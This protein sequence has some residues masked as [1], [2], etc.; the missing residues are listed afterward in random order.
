MINTGHRVR[1]ARSSIWC[2]SG[3]HIHPQRYTLHSPLASQ[4]NSHISSLRNQHS[5]R[6]TQVKYHTKHGSP[7]CCMAKQRFSVLIFSRHTHTKQHSLY[8]FQTFRFSSLRL[9]LN[10]LTWKIWWAPNNFS[11]WQMG[12][13]SAFKGLNNFPNW[14]NVPDSG[15]K[16]SNTPATLRP[17]FSLNSFEVQKFAKRHPKQKYSTLKSKSKT[18][19]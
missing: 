6:H 19:A 14:H 18:S 3:Q 12:F 10:P 5:H 15:C 9:T 16:T 13:N 8:E 17:G 4:H 11:R 2:C 7:C 1:V